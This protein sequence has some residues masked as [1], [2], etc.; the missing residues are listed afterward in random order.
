MR[1]CHRK[2][3]RIAGGRISYEDVVTADGQVLVKAG[4]EMRNCSE[5]RGFRSSCIHS[6]RSDL[7]LRFGVARNAMA[8]IHRP[9]GGN[10]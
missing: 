5:D 8:A 9:S 1:S 2:S 3:W 6:Q 7:S 10:W 4:Q